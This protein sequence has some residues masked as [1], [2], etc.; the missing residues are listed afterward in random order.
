MNEPD[1]VVAE[2]SPEDFLEMLS[3]RRAMPIIAEG[4]RM[5]ITGS[6]DLSNSDAGRAVENIPECEILGDLFAVGC[7]NLKSARCFVR[8]SALFDMCGI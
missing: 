6:V 7:E 1:R 5:V 2:I 3:G 4:G 8:G